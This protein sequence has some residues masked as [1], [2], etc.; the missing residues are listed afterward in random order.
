MF[1]WNIL[2]QHI[3]EPQAEF[4]AKTQSGKDRQEIQGKQRSGAS[5]STHFLILICALCS[6]GTLRARI[7]SVIAS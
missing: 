2:Y 3:Q 5:N 6:L 7:A 1:H 4:R